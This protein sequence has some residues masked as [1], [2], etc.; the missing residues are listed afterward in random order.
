MFQVLWERFLEDI[1]EGNSPADFHAMSVKE[2]AS[3]LDKQTGRYTDDLTTTRRNINRLQSS[4]ETAVK[5]NLGSPIDRE[6]IVQTCKW[7]GTS[8]DNFGYRINPFTVVARPLQ[9]PKA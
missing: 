1:K 5:K 8:D 3:A 2:I 6:D 4:I 9:A 7:Q